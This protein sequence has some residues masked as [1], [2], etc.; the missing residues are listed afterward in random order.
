MTVANLKMCLDVLPV[1]VVGL[2]RAGRVV[3]WNREMIR[4]TGIPFAAVAGCH[5][6]EVAKR[7]LVAEESDLKGLI[8]T[9]KEG[10]DADVRRA[11]KRL[12]LTS[13]TE[14]MVS[15]RVRFY[16]LAAAGRDAGGPDDDDESPA[17]VGVFM[18]VAAAYG[19][20][21]AEMPS[22]SSYHEAA[23]IPGP[24][25]LSFMLSRQLALRSRYNIPFSLLLLTLESYQDMIAELGLDAWQETMRAICASLT[26]VVRRADS[27]GGYDQATFW[28]LLANAGLPASQAVAEK[29]LYH[30]AG[31]TV[32]NGN[33][34]FDAFVGGAVAHPHESPEELVQR[35]LNA[36]ALARQAPGH[37]HIEPAVEPAAK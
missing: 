34:S 18:P 8:A 9:S 22:L 30:A 2:N 14:A 33:R 26:S 3:L 21:T 27:V 32:E 28:L 13:E 11:G 19:G 29:M 24:Y 5:W 25:E 1:G 20:E 15:V 17:L 6:G 4:L 7:L 31:I 35:A 37:T 10:D 16:P 36:L 12:L 23:G